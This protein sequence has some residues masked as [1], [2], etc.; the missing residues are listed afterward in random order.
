MWLLLYICLRANCSSF[1]FKVTFHMPVF[2]PQRKMEP[3][4]FD[5]SNEP[6][7]AVTYLP[8]GD[9]QKFA[10]AVD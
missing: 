7:M 1:W 3:V 8:A 6:F 5:T 10:A 9:D 4:P 2:P